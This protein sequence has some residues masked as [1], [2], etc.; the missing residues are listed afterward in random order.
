[1]PQNIRRIILTKTA[2]L[3]QMALRRVL[4]Y[5][6][7]A[8]ARR[9]QAPVSKPDSLTQTNP[10]SLV[11]LPPKTVAIALTR[12]RFATV[13]FSSSRA[14]SFGIFP[15]SGRETVKFVEFSLTFR[16]IVPVPFFRNA[17]YNTI[18]D[19]HWHAFSKNRRSDCWG[20]S[21]E[22]WEKW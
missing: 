2:Q 3:R 1:M 21:P 8:A 12:L 11:N 22:S 13:I 4:G 9:D 7:R 6:K 17:C 10:K 5:N 15:D 14:F 16:R 20:K 19:R 18:V